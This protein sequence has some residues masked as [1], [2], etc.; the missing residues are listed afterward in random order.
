[1][2]LKLGAEGAFVRTAEGFSLRVPG[3]SVA[4]VV[5]TV[6]AGDGFAAGVLSARLEG[7]DW[8]DALARGNWVGAQVIQQIGDVDG[9]PRRAQLPPA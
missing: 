8:A 1:V 5:D 3:V 2:V 9:L 6:G 4:K 7:L